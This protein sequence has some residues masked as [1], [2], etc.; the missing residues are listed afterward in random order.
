MLKA[1]EKGF[2]LIEVL[3]ALFILSSIMTVATA[4]VIVTMKTSSQNNE[5]NVNLYQVQ[6]AGNWI[7]RDALMAQTV[8]IDNPG[9]LLNLSW[10]DWDDNNFSRSEEHTSELQSR[11]HL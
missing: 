1:S 2:T 3:V 6:N 7:S 4:A 11:L 5:W 9:V 8:D 10:S